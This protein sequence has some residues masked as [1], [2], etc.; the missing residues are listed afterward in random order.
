MEVVEIQ[1]T[2]IETTNTKIVALV[3]Q[4]ENK[5]LGLRNVFCH[6]LSCVV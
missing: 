6:Q 3:S 1:P 2:T 5:P 4:K